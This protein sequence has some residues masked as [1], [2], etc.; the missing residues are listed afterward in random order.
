MARTVP[1]PLP[2]LDFAN[3]PDSDALE[4][5]GPTPR[6]SRYTRLRCGLWLVPIAKHLEQLQQ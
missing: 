5:S 3:A 1:F 4:S 2:P 6:C